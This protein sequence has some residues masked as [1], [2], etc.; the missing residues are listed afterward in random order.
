MRSNVAL[1]KDVIEEMDYF[2]KTLKK[3][4]YDMSRQTMIR[5]AVRDFCEK[6]EKE[7][8][9]LEHVPQGQK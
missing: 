8:I 7:P 1:D 6:Y 2:I 9:V 4:G 3:R 5:I